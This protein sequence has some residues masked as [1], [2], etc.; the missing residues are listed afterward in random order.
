MKEDLMKKSMKRKQRG[1]ATQD[2][3]IAVAV[4]LVLGALAMAVLPGILSDNKV[5]KEARNTTQLLTGI[6]GLYD[7]NYTGLDTGSVV[8]AKLNNKLFVSPTATTLQHTWG[9]ALAVSVGGATGT[10]PITTFRL[11]FTGVP[12]EVCLQFVKQLSG[13]A[14]ALFV[15]GT[16]AGTHDVVPAG[17]STLNVSRAATQCAA[18]AATGNIILVSQ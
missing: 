14:Y 5:N 4:L 8:T 13:A 6:Q 1:F 12:S 18:L 10:T 9:G 17:T 3:L 11:Q 2:V 15:G 7:Q 16:T